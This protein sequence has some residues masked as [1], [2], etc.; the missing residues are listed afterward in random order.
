VLGADT[1]L[2]VAANIDHTESDVK[3]IA[4]EDLVLSMSELPLHV[5][6]G[7]QNIAGVVVQART[8]RELWL[9]LLSAAVMLMV[10]EAL[11]A[12]WSTQHH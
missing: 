7:D 3:V 2:T 11:F 1:P 5:I 12:R 6:G 10:I 9:W 8:G 4:Q